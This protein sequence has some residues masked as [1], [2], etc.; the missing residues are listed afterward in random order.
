MDISPRM[1]YPDAQIFARLGGLPGTTALNIDA[2]FNL[3]KSTSPGDGQTYGNLTPLTYPDGYI[4]TVYPTPDVQATV[5]T[6]TEWLN[7][8]RFVYGDFFSRFQQR[9][10]SPFNTKVP[11]LALSAVDAKYELTGTIGPVQ[12]G[13]IVPACI[14]PVTAYPTQASNIQTWFIT[15]VTAGWEAATSGSMNGAFYV[16]LNTTTSANI[17]RSPQNRVVLIVTGLGDFA[18]PPR[19]LE[20]QVKDSTGRPLGIKSLPFTH[21]VNNLN[22]HEWD[23]AFLVQKNKLMTVDV[24]YDSTGAAVPEVL[25]AQW[26]TVDYATTEN[27]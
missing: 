15:S 19:M 11:A 2:L 17:V 13:T 14:R 27:S 1:D 3:V 26:Q 10:I 21:A 20:F 6:A 22:I 5:L 8:Y 16:Q 24:N 12:N 25:G 9:D 23:T 18:S 4:T 7:F